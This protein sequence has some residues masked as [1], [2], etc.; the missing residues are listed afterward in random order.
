MTYR[1]IDTVAIMKSLL[2]AGQEP[3]DEML[4][5]YLQMLDRVAPETEAKPMSAPVGRPQPA[6]AGGGAGVELRVIE[7]EDRGNFVRAKVSGLPGK[8]FPMYVSAWEADAGVVRPLQS[9]AVI[10]ADVEEKPNPNGKAP[11][12]NLRNVVVTAAGTPA[13]AANDIPF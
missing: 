3:T 6:P 9:G 7:V 13:A 2:E 1:R 5:H 8:K 11:F 4:T 10:R 12:V